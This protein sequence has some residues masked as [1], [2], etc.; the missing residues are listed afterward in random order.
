MLVSSDR[1]TSIREGA[2]DAAAISEGGAELA[3]GVTVSDVLLKQI[4]VDVLKEKG[5][6]EQQ[7]QSRILETLTSVNDAIWA[8]NSRVANLEE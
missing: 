4:L 1:Q 3:A 2:A 5:R 7:Q 6:K 8:L